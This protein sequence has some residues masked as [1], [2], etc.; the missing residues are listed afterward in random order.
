[1]NGRAGAGGAGANRFRGRVMVPAISVRLNHSFPVEMQRFVKA[2][3]RDGGR[4]GG[5]ARRLLLESEVFGVTVESGR[6]RYARRPYFAGCIFCVHVVMHPPETGWRARMNN[7]KKYRL[8]LLDG[9][10]VCLQSFGDHVMHLVLT[11]RKPVDLPRWR[12]A[13][14][15]SVDA[16]P[17]LGCRLVSGGWRPHWQRWTSQELDAFEWCDEQP[18]RDREQQVQD[19]L[20]QPMNCQTEPMVRARLLRGARDTICLNVNCVPID[21]RGLLIYLERLCDIYNQLA[22]DPDH[23]PASSGMDRRSTAALVK[24]FRWYDVF[25]LLFFALRNQWVDRATA[26]NWR[27]PCQTAKKIDRIFFC[28]AF[29]PATFH[30]LQDFRRRQGFSFNDLMLAAFYSGLHAII[31]PAVDDCFCVLNTYDLRRYEGPDAVARV[32]NYSSFVNANVRMEKDLPFLTLAERVREA[33]SERKRHFPG[34][35]EGPFIWPIFRFL[36]FSMARLLVEKLLQHRGEDIPVMTNVGVIDIERLALDGE[37]LESLIP[38]APLEYPPKLTVTVATV[39]ETV[40]LSV[41][42]S[43]NHFRMTD[44]ERLFAHMEKV[45]AGLSVPT[46]ML[47]GVPA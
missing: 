46:P 40:T 30:S 32:A 1:M 43:R 11:S 13:L 37:R 47:C 45:L 41:G 34:I 26:H 8:T 22:R 36:P 3:G 35:T 24:H 27:F 19:F 7:N 29:S 14:R 28:R 12:R 17:I 25:P 38:Y 21:G 31:H 42:F 16:E 5:G 9:V 20:H 33:M 10:N 15:L 39:G 18:A 23:V 4:V 44:I 6:H 2:V